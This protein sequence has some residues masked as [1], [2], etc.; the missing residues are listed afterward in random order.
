M[1]VMPLHQAI[2][3]AYKGRARQ[4]DL[5]EWLGVGQPT[6][7]R[8][9][10]GEVVPSVHEIAALEDALG[11]RRGWILIASGFVDPASDVEGAIDLDPVLSDDSRHLLKT[12]YRAATEQAAPMAAQGMTKDVAKRRRVR[13]PA[14]SPEGE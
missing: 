10:R 8:W 5:A 11:L 12:L 4:E 13:R 6:V 1:A 3:S 9:A 2:R 7:S 14:P